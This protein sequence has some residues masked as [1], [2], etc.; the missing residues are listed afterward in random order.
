MKKISSYTLR[1]VMRVSMEHE[2][3]STGS[4]KCLLSDCVVD[5]IDWTAVV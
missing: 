3:S 1:T 4:W 2:N 5:W